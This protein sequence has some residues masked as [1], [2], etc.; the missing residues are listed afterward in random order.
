MKSSP[1][2]PSKTILDR[3]ETAA[4][5]DIP[6]SQESFVMDA[7]SEQARWTSYRSKYR[8]AIPRTTKPTGIYNCHGF[9]FAASRTGI[10]RGSDVRAIL[11]DD[12]YVKITPARSLAGDVVLYIADG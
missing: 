5:N 7:K 8:G 1:E 3:F 12:G 2:F 11:H 10:E 4:G 6:N 9:V